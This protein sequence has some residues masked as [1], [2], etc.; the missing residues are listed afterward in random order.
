LDDDTYFNTISRPYIDVFHEPVGAIGYPN[1]AF[2]AHVFEAKAGTWLSRVIYYLYQQ[3]S[4]PDDWSMWL[5][6]ED[7]A[8]HLSNRFLVL[9]SNA[10]IAD[11][12][13]EGDVPDG[14]DPDD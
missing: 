2:T 7:L 14:Y 6:T 10:A 12:Y 1:S 8:K 4:L 3:P 9:G 5:L 13:K 11:H